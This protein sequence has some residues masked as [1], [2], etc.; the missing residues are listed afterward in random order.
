VLGSDLDGAGSDAGRARVAA[1]AV[2]H[3]TVTVTDGSGPGDSEWQVLGLC[4][5]GPGPSAVVVDGPRTGALA[6]LSVID[7][8][9]EGTECITV[10]VSLHEDLPMLRGAQTPLKCPLW[11]Q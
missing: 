8:C 3:G 7:G 5:A 4:L 6:A 11:M 2:R 10:H 1:A 9:S